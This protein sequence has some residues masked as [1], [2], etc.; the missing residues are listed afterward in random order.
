MIDNEVASALK[1]VQAAFERRP[2]LALHADSAAVAQW[3]GDL[4]VVT[5][6]P[7][8]RSIISDLPTELG[9]GGGEITPGWYA[10]AGI[11]ACTTTC[12]AIAAQL[13]GIALTRLEVTV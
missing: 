4:R 3:Q 12:I 2:G 13:R 8:G 7:S 1:R 5:T 10:R 6:H 11:A 9:G